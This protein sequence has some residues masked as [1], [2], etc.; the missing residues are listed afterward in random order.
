[1]AVNLRNKT[2]PSVPIHIY[3]LAMPAMEKFRAETKDVGN[4]HICKSSGEVAEK[5]EFIITILPEGAHV[6]AAYTSIDG[7]IAGLS[8]KTSY[9]LLDCSTID[10]TTSLIVGEAI[11]TS[12]AKADFADAPV[13]GGTM[14]A[15]KGTLTFMVGAAA[16]SQTF[17][18]MRPVLEKMGRTIVPCGAPSYGLGAKLSN[19]YLS[20]LCAIATA[21][22]MNLG[23][24]IGLDPHV[25][26][27]VF[28]VSTG[29]NYVNNECNPVPGVCPDAPPSKDY[30]P[31]FKVQLMKKDFGL[32]VK[33]AAD[34]GARLAL[35]EAGMRVYTEASDDP[36]CRNRD[37]RVVRDNY[38][39]DI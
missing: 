24:R 30:A 25:L 38:N 26:S 37:S 39:V 6:K 17:E 16:D 19:N 5:S 36:R 31:G 28:K 20:G 34:V 2:A 8:S 7:I 15:V 35:G 22:A 21:E 18:T 23:M 4:V 13:S 29:S 11:K 27:N 32:A 14:G 12:G 1:M 33:T 9:T 10:T 3:D